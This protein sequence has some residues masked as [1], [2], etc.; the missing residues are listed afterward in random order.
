MEGVVK[1][2]EKA[3]RRYAK[4][5]SFAVTW[6][7]RGDGTASRKENKGATMWLSGCAGDEGRSVRG[8]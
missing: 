5:F 8:C 2:E 3:E 7:K 6:R 4:G 1:G